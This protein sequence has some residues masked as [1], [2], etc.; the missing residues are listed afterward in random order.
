MSMRF[1][2]NFLGR[3]YLVFF[4]VLKSYFKMFNVVQHSGFSELSRIWQFPRLWAAR[5]R[6]L[7]AGRLPH[8]LHAGGGPP[9]PPCQVRTSQR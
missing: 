5:G 3:N 9:P 2:H 7:G 8:D 4:S 1:A 6:D